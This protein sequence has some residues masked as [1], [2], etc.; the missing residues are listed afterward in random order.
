MTFWLILTAVSLY[1]IVRREV[2]LLLAEA[3]SE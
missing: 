1:I 2:L 3:E